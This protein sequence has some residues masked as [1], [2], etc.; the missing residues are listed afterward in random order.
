M[1]NRLEFPSLGFDQ[2][3]RALGL[4]DGAINPPPHVVQWYTGSPKPGSTGI[5]VIAGHVA[6]YGGKDGI[7]AQLPQ[8]SAGDKVTIGY[9]SGGERTFQVYAKEAVGKKELQRDARV[10]GKSST[11]I[12]ALITCDDEAASVNGHSVRNYV[13]WAK[14]I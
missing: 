4:N 9:A 5:S 3:V 7:F 6:P 13:V 2:P 10:W 8:L 14:P 11:P 1:P 12:V